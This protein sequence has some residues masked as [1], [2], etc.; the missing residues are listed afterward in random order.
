MMDWQLHRESG[1]EYA[2]ARCCGQTYTFVNHDGTERLLPARRRSGVASL[3]ATF[4]VAVPLLLIFGG[5]R[6]A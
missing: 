3:V 1:A 2:V 5:S 4:I 6:R